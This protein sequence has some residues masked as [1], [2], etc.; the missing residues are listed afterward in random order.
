METEAQ[1]ES[2]KKWG[3]TLFQGYFFA[4]PEIIKYVEIPLNAALHFQIIEKLNKETPNISEIAAFITR[5][6]SL[7]YRLLRLINTY[8]FGVPKKITSIKQAIVIIGVEGTK[9]WLYVL[10]LYEM[11]EGIGKGRTKALVDNS[12][13]RAKLC[14]LLAIATGKKNAEEYF[15]AGM[16][17]LVNL[18]IKREWHD[19]LP[20]MS[21]SDKVEMTLLGQQTEITD[22]L[23][24]AASLEVLDIQKAKQLAEKIGVT[25]HELSAL[26]KEAN[27]WAQQID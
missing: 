24:I 9:K 7:T 4:K 10:T 25:M 18:I 17:S 13:T 19:I 21:L 12:L 1:F 8:S 3:Y 20:E 11:G 26:S 22:I 15:L 14:E 27:R 2:A 23:E 6:M 5:D 16:F